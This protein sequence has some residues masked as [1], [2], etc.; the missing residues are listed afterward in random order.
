MNLHSKRE[1]IE[2]WRVKEKERK[3]KCKD[4]TSCNTKADENQLSLS[5]ESN[6]DDKK[7]NKK[8]R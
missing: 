6:E 5:Q 7:K 3:G 2:S 8:K 4:I 1:T